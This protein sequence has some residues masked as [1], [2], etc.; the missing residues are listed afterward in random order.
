MRS[1]CSS[2]AWCPREYLE[3]V[4]H[5]PRLSSGSGYNLY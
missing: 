2:R 1:T 4:I 5:S 3:A